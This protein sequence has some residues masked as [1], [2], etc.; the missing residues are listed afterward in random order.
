MSLNEVP[1]RVTVLFVLAF[2]WICLPSA[3][4]SVSTGTITG[5]VVDSSGAVLANAALAVNGTT[6]IGGTTT[7][8]VNRD[9]SYRATAL[10]PGSYELT[11]MHAGLQS[12][13]RTGI[14]VAAGSAIVV[15]FMLPIERQRE[16]VMVVSESPLIDATSAAVPVRLDQDLLFNLPV[17]RDVAGLIN[18]APGVGSDVAFGGSQRSNEILVD[19][20]RTTGALTQDPLAT[21]NH[22][23]V[24][25]VNV[26]ALGAP[27][28]HGGFTGVAANAVLRSGTNRFNGLAEHWTTRPSWLAHNTGTLSQSLQRQFTSRHLLDW[29][30]SNGQLGGPV[31][32]DRL[33]FFTGVSHARYNDRPAGYDGPG[34]RDERNVQWLLKPTASLSPAVRVEGLIERGEARVDAEYLSVQFPLEATNDVYYPQ[35]LWNTSANAVVGA[36]TMLEVRHGGLVVD[37]REDPH[38]PATRTGPYPHVDALTGIWSHNTNVLFDSDS[39]VFTTSATITRHSDQLRLGSHVFRGGVEHERTTARNFVGYPGGRFYAD[40]PGGVTEVVLWD[41]QTGRASTHRVVTY[42]QDEWRVAPRLTLS[43]GVRLEFNRGSVPA[44]PHTFVTNTFTPRIGIAWDVTPSHRTVVRFHYGRY[45]DPI[46]A[47]RIVQDDTTGRNPETRA[48]VVGPDQFEII[49]VS[50][51]A[52]RF[53]IDEDL[54]HSHV[55]Q[56]VVG[57]ERE[58]F[59]SVSL[60]TQYIRRR[61]DDYMGLI[62]TGSTYMPVQR[63]DLGADGLLNTADDGPMLDVFLQANPGNEFH[64]YTNPENAFNRY[65]AVQ[66]VGRKRYEGDWQLQG[67]YTWSRNRGTVGNRQHVNAGGFDLGSPGRF[68][69]PNLAINAYGRAHF[70]PTHEVKLLGSYRLPWIGGTMVSGV[71]QHTTGQAWGRTVLVTGLLGPRQ[72][73]VEPVGTRRASALNL[74]SLRVDKTIPLRQYGGA[75]GIFFDVFNLGNQGVPDSQRTNAVEERS[76]PR[77][78]V[79]NFWLDPRTLRVGV[80][81]SF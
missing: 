52:N 78:G 15:D 56:M 63:P 59:G 66:I 68:V 19:G 43:P 22:N 64:V 65:D 48:R 14:V 30:E 8:Q 17:P 36:A 4:Q 7:I 12:V 33:W 23:W 10:P 28:E 44:R 25:E 67:S 51:P 5:T 74:G 11:A 49:S 1:M 39:H 72:I 34:S 50:N 77:F 29:R 70:D 41:G 2:A 18:L 3:A 35:T 55:K 81:A 62:D 47:S 76:G 21:V 38:P 16:A 6:L 58:L 9:G 31:I 75:I 27:A 54:R 37:S 69:N 13:R 60:Q 26:V 20:V 32:R 73:R 42:V 40:L 57:I 80:R 24:Q 53:A 46:F 71:Y 61:F 45:F 79:P